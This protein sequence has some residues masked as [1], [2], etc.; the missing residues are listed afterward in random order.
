MKA[1]ITNNGGKSILTLNVDFNQILNDNFNTVCEAIANKGIFLKEMCAL[2]NKKSNPVEEIIPLLRNV[3]NRIDAEKSL[4][5]KFGISE[6]T[7][8]HILEMSLSELTGLT[9]ECLKT[10]FESFIECVKMIRCIDKDD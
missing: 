5:E 2:F 6:I 9:E 7:A 1:K 10:E 4:C 3:D 8:H